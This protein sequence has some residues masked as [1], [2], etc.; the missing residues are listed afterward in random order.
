MVTTEKKYSRNKAVKK[1]NETRERDNNSSKPV[2][3]CVQ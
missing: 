2:V 3:K 1:L